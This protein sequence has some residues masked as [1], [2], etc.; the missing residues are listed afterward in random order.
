LAAKRIALRAMVLWCCLNASTAF[1]PT[2]AK[3]RSLA[4]AV[5]NA[6]EKTPAVVCAL[7]SASNQPPAVIS[8]STRGQLTFMAFLPVVQHSFCHPFDH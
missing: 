2:S 4:S 6:I 5:R 3:G 8:Q 1:W 7:P